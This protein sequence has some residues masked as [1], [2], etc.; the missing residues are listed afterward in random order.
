MPVLGPTPE[1]WKAFAKIRAK[2]QQTRTEDP[3]AWTLIP[4][5]KFFDVEEG[6]R[7]EVRSTQPGSYLV[8]PEVE[9]V[10]EGPSNT[11]TRISTSRSELVKLP[12]G[13]HRAHVELAKGGPPPPYKTEDLGGGPAYPAWRSDVAEFQIVR[14]SLELQASGRLVGQSGGPVRAVLEPDIPGAKL[15]IVYSSKTHPAEPA[16]RADASNGSWTGVGQL[17]PGVY[18][19]HAVATIDEY[20]VRS[21]VSS[22]TVRDLRHNKNEIDSGAVA[23][24]Q[25]ADAGSAP[26][27]ATPITGSSQP[28]VR[29]DP[30]PPTTPRNYGW[31]AF[32]LLL[33]AIVMAS[34]FYRTQ[35]GQWPWQPSVLAVSK[36]EPIPAHVK[37]I[38]IEWRLQVRGTA[39]VG[40]QRVESIRRDS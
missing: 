4:E 32:A 29:R 6:A 10:V 31:T 20:T 22:A 16:K 25:A 28:P 21:N 40:Q 17:E 3:L 1:Q 7:F 18:V 37:P 27:I 14:V 12:I 30:D 26:T 33:M 13:K 35:R 36:F 11:R 8:P 5:S 15:E 39:D 2:R 23:P 9:L 34:T 24:V 19:L 38:E